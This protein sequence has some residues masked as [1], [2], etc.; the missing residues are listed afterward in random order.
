MTLEEIL[1]QDTSKMSISEMLNMLG[2][3]AD[4]DAVQAI[5]E[6]HEDDTG[7][8]MEE[9]EIG[10]GGMS[11]LGRRMFPGIVERLEAYERGEWNP[12]EAEEE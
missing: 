3:L 6:R 2:S 9:D 11:E 1:A 5:R 8:P 10:I 4:L 12:D 7:I